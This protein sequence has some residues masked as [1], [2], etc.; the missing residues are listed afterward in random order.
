MRV[1]K[2]LTEKASQRLARGKDFS[3]NVVQGD[4][5]HLSPPLLKIMVTNYLP[6]WMGDEGYI[7]K[8]FKHL[9]TSTLNVVVREKREEVGERN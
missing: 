6:L 5:N 2:G 7:Q 4:L 1:L 9:P 3:Q 8:S